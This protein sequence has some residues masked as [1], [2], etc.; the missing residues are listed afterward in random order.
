MRDKKIMRNMRDG[1]LFLSP[2]LIMVVVFLIYPIFSGLWIS[3]HEWAILGN[4]RPFVGL[5][6]YIQVF[7]DDVFWKS[8]ANTVYFVV[9]S[10][11]LLV[12]LGLLFAIFLNKEIPGRT[13][14]RAA[15]FLPYLLSISVVGM[16]WLWLLQPRHGLISY[17]LGRISFL[18]PLAQINWLGD[19]KYAMPSIAITTLWW[20][21]GFNM[22]LFLAGLQDIPKE[23]T[24]AAKIDGT[25]ALQ[26][27]WYITLPLLQR[28]TLFV[29][30]MQI[31]RS[32]QIFGQVYIM[33]GGG[34]YGATRVLVQYIYENGFK[35]W[36]M[37]YA[38]AMAY[39][40]LVI[41]MFF[42]FLQLKIGEKE[43]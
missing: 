7:K 13:F 12:I 5:A 39:V 23:L 22:V 9:L 2:Y 43:E 33:T 41:I 21:V 32:F 18:S 3:L 6:N 26:E 20:T 17:Y 36:K 1:Y 24:D 25:N 14:F 38:S 10:T 40:M 28:I 4:E 34:P 27:F 8:L 16:L 42:T 31:I 19:P 37:G 29:V 11:P 30:I 35:Y 15:I